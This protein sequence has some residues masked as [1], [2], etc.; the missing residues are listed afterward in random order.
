MTYGVQLDPEERVEGHPFSDLEHS[1]ADLGTM[2]FMAHQ[3]VNTY[4]DPQVCDFTM[5]FGPVCQSD[6]QGR[7]FRI[8][9][10]QP[11]RLFNLHS[12][13]AVGFF[14]RKRPQAD[15]RPLVRADKRFEHEFEHYPGLLSLSTVR[16]A[17]GDFGNLVVFSDADSIARWNHNP[18][19]RDLVAKISP[20]YYRS[21][22]LNN[23]WLPE[24]LSDPDRLWIERVKYIDYTVDPPWRAERR[25]P[26]PSADAG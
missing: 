15:I 26:R 2:R 22:R 12:L 13:A 25:L 16:V 9:Y 14:G 3:L 5:R 18:V 21:V 4:Q 8:Y 24:G 17:N 23:G 7:H 6:P 20:P 1:Q 11:D 19:H 10:L